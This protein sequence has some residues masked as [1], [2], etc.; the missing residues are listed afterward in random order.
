MQKLI[1]TPRLVPALIVAVCLG[2]LATAFASEIWGGLKPC[3][4]CI[5]QRWAYG[6]AAGFGLLGV[7]LGASL[8]LR[9]LMVALAGLSFLAGA[10]IAF[11][12]VGVEQ[13]W[14]RGT[15]AC[16][17]PSFDP[18]LSLEQLR[19]AM[20]ATDFVSC[21]VIPWSLFGISMAGYNV[22]FSLGLGL[23]SLWVVTR[24]G[25]GATA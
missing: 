8:V 7:I 14:W 25:R 6:V 15:D 13:L 2:T 17:A 3:I 20:L 22:P 23:A 11:F 9:R 18:D 5:Y 16:H 21:D 1:D 24:M 10:G 19:E 12:H 4:L